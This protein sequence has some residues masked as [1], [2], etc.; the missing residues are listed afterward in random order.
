MMVTAVFA[1]VVAANWI[2]VMVHIDNLRASA[3]HSSG[4]AAPELLAQTDDFRSLRCPHG[5]G[6][7]RQAEGASPIVV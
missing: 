2:A 4:D 6:V 1:A 3:A 7:S 5:E